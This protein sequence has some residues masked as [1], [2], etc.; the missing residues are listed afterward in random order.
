MPM[1]ADEHEL[2]VRIDMNVDTLLASR[3][4]QESRLRKLERFKSWITGILAVI[5]SGLGIHH[6]N[7]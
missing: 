4:D 3:I 5:G 7:Q 2:L 1:N 6:V